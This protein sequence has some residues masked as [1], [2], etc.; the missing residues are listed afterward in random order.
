MF[1]TVGGCSM[2]TKKKK[3]MIVLTVVTSLPIALISWTFW[4]NTALQLN[5]YT[6]SSGKLPIIFDGYRIAHVSDL[7]NAEMGKG[8]ENL[9]DMLKK[10]KPDIIAITGD[11]INYYNTDVEIALHFAE[12][13]IKIA[14]CY[15]VTGNHEAKVSVYDELKNGLTELGVIVLGGERIDLKKS[16]DTI[17]LIGVNDPRFKVDYLFSDEEVVVKTQIQENMKGS[18]G[19]TLVL[20]HRPEFFE[21]YTNCGVDLVLSGHAHGGQFRFPF[22]GGFFAPNQGL[23]PK[24]DSGLYTEGNTNMIVSRGIGNSAFPF[25]FNNRPE[26]I[27][28]ELQSETA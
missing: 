8:N 21:V 25:R 3:L 5:T 14:P 4:G 12:E 19:F 26:V 16:G 13:A 9:L 11:L 1:Q 7:H 6:V 22:V 24:Y 27:L 17:T 2:T 18:D 23:F 10:A 15:F 20:S 28:I